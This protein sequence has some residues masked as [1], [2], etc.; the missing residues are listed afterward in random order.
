MSNAHDTSR[1]GGSARPWVAASTAK[2][3]EL[4]AAK[5]EWSRRLLS[6]APAAASGIR[7][8]NAAVATKPDANVVGVGIGEKI[9]DG[10]GTGIHAIKFFVKVKYPDNQVPERARLPEQINGLPVD[11]EQVGVWRKFSSA[12]ATPQ[13][14]RHRRP[15][16][17]PTPVMPDPKT[18]FRPAQPGCSIGFQDPANQFVMAGTFGA[19]VKDQEGIYILSNNHVLA[20]ED[21]LPLGSPIFQPGLLDGG[22]ADTDQIAELTRAVRLQAGQPNKVDCAIAKPTKASLV[23][24]EI[25]HIGPPHGVAEAQIDMNVHKFGRTTSYTVGRITSVDTDVTVQYDVGNLVFTSQIII[26][27]QTGDPFSDAG[28]S[29]S[30]ILDR[31]TNNA[32]GLLF[33]GSRASTIANQIGDVL[34]ALNVTL[35]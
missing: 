21:Q 29:G 3:S 9:V 13:R 34:S 20:N 12:V 1:G 30:L 11:V 2:L 32:V 4:K 25:L 26:V 27:G 18:K 22:N 17:A 15:R 14:R 6:S 28:D 33:A 7:V 10:K 24:K 16:P 19:V 35:A 23:S 31:A 5:Q 8:F